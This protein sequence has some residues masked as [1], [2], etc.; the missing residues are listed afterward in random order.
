MV[1]R[2]VRTREP[3][4][5]EVKPGQK[6]RYSVMSWVLKALRLED[7][8]PTCARC[9]THLELKSDQVLSPTDDYVIQGVRYWE[10]PRCEDRIKRP[11]AYVKDIP[12]GDIF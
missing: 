6:I 9:W 11:Y 8:S 5:T 10:C 3:K 4:L 12:A 7:I 2:S 1:I